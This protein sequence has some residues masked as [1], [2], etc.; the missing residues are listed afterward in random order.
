MVTGK[1][2]RRHVEPAAS[3]KVPRNPNMRCRG[4]FKVSVRKYGF[5][6]CLLSGYWTLRVRLAEV[7]SW[8]DHVLRSTWDDMEN[9]SQRGGKRGAG[10]VVDCIE[11]PVP[12][13]LAVLVK[14]CVLLTGM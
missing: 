9:D 4:F 11:A 8:M 10:S 1:G 7:R 12:N 14:A 5:G 3:P 13:C 2:L 6:N